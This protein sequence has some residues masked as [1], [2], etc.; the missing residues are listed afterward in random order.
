MKSPLRWVL[1]A[2]AVALVALQWQERT[3][4]RDRQ[5]LQER[6]VQARAEAD[7]CRRDLVVS[8]ADFRELDRRV[9]SLRATVDT[10]ESLDPRGVPA[11]RYEEY[12]AV[13]DAYNEGVARWEAAAAELRASEEGCRDRV[14]AY[15]QLADSARGT[16]ATPATPP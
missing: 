11:A 3:E 10:L 6:V 12:L 4:R 14:E 2:V 8:E 16:P 7:A 5:R 9:D 13:V 15:N 1:V